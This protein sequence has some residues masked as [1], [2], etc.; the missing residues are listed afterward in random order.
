MV[1]FL[2]FLGK[3]FFCALLSPIVAGDI[4]GE[5]DLSSWVD[6]TLVGL[7]GIFGALGPDRLEIFV[8]FVWGQFLIV[9]HFLE[10][11]R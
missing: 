3:K 6:P 9:D 10:D 2:L 7:A 8:V 5:P 11:G 4:G 1:Q